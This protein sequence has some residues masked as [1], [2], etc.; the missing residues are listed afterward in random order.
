MKKIFWIIWVGMAGVPALAQTHT[1]KITR[2]FSFEKASPDNA[3]MIANINGDVKVVGYDGTKIQVEV[4]KTITGKTS[5]RLEEGKAAIQLG[6]IDDVD[7]I[8]LY[9]EGTC[10]KF[11]KNNRN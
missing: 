7:S 2:E 5:T 1:E 6:V 10:S 8:V 4:T 3:L 9:V 11:S